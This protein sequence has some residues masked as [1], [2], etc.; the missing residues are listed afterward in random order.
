MKLICGTI[1]LKEEDTE[2]KIPTV[3]KRVENY[4]GIYAFS[5]Y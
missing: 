2:R 5:R 1:K 4:C 3:N